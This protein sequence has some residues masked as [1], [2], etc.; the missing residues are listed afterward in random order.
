MSSKTVAANACA[1]GLVVPPPAHFI[2]QHGILTAPAF[3]PHPIPRVLPH[4]FWIWLTFSAGFAFCLLLDFALSE[5]VERHNAWRVR[6]HA[7]AERIAH[8]S[9][10]P[11]DE[12]GDDHE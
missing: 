10:N 8:G 3:I 9:R 11:G 5:I 12:Q 4:I 6:R 2:N 7:E 1:R